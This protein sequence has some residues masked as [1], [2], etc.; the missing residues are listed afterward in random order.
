MTD[1]LLIAL[2]EFFAAEP[3]PNQY[4]CGCCG[5]IFDKGRSDNEARAE[6]ERIFGTALHAGG[7]PPVIVCDDCYTAFMAWA[8]ERGYVEET[9]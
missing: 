2:S 6:A 9:E 3:G 7:E 8:K 1:A 4:R 5:G